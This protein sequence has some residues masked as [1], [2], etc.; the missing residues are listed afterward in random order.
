[1]LLNTLLVC[2][3]L[4]V[5]LLASLSNRVVASGVPIIDPRFKIERVVDGLNFPTNMAFLGKNDILFLEKDEGTVNRISNGTLMSEPLLKVSVSNQAERGMLGLAVSKDAEPG[6]T[7]VFLYFSEVSK[8]IT[9]PVANRLYRYELVNNALVSPKLLLN[10]PAEPGHGDWPDHNGGEIIIGPDKNIYLAVGDIGGHQTLTQ[11]YHKS[12]FHIGSAIYQISENGES[13]AN[14]LGDEEPFNRIYAYGIRNSFGM[15]FDPITKNL[16]DTENGPGY[17]D[18]I[19]LVKPGFN[20]GW[21]KVQGVWESN[22]NS[23]LKS[24]IFRGLHNELV[25]FGGRGRY[26][27]PELTWYKTVGVSALK[28][29]NSDKFGKQYEN[30]MFVGDVNYGNLYHFDLNEN[31]TALKLNKTLGDK[32]VSDIDE[33]KDVTFAKLPQAITD[34]QVGPDGYLYI[35][36]I[37]YDYWNY[38]KDHKMTGGGA[39]YRIMPK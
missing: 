5:F 23:T 17:G 38:E 22:S 34:I 1:M 4:A 16:W 8:N 36:T 19:N 7:L 39:I 14:I 25:N 30:D 10:L 11:N 37:P 33:L 28:F 13:A 9:S 35:L 32:T 15:D 18:E 12:L 6:H 2:S 3:V 24:S 31:R 29:F 27:A 26:S 20:S 21:A